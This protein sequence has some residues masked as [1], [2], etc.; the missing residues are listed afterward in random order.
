MPSS[1]IGLQRGKTAAL[2][3]SNNTYYANKRRLATL[4]TNWFIASKKVLVESL[5]KISFVHICAS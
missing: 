5:Q 4:S 3:G 2:L 1:L